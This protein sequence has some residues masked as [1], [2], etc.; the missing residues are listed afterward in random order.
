MGPERRA[1]PK[2]ECQWTTGQLSTGDPLVT[3]FW[4]RASYTELLAY[5]DL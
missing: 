3:P 5:S 1:Q 2:S 4:D